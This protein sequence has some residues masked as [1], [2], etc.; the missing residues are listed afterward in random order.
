M[1]FVSDDIK[2]MTI[3]EEKCSISVNTKRNKKKSNQIN[4]N[5]EKK[6]P[7]IILCYKQL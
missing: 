4:Y 7:E 2:K 5:K 3:Y 6:Y 1:L